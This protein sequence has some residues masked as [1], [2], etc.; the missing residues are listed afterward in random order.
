MPLRPATVFVLEG[1]DLVTVGGN[2][3]Q[4][5]ELQVW[6]DNTGVGIGNPIL[7]VNGDM[8]RWMSSDGGA[9]NAP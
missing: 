2:K 8:V 5:G 7:T 1:M 6:A 4:F 3:V 9:Y